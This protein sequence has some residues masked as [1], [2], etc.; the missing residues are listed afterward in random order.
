MHCSDSALK[1]KIEKLLFCYTICL[2][3]SIVFY[4]S[5]QIFLNCFLIQNSLVISKLMFRFMAAPLN[6]PMAT[7]GGQWSSWTNQPTIQPVKLSWDKKVSPEMSYIQHKEEFFFLFPSPGL[8]HINRP[9][10]YMLHSHL[11]IIRFILFLFFFLFSPSYLYIFS[12]FTTDNVS[13]TSI[14]SSS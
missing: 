10:H 9:T 14:T 13:I 2:P 1:Q 4:F 8:H 11:M 5:S 6:G 7:F 3:L 12:F